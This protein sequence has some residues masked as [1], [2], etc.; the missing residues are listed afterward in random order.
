MDW[1]KTNQGA[2]TSFLQVERVS[3]IIKKV[4]GGQ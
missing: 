4:G 3:K 1:V 2:I